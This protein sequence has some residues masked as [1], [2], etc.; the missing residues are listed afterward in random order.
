MLYSR[1]QV[2]YNAQPNDII[3][4]PHYETPLCVY[5]MSHEVD[6]VESIRQ[7]REFMGEEVEREASVSEEQAGRFDSLWAD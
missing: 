5:R 3:T 4:G 1:K 2:V 7:I 6:A